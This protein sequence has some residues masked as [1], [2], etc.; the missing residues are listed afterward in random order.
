[1]RT[2]VIAKRKLLKQ[3]AT[4][5]EHCWRWGGVFDSCSPSGSHSVRS[6]DGFICKHFQCVFIA[7]KQMFAFWP[8]GTNQQMLLL[9]FPQA[10]WHGA[11]PSV[12]FPFSQELSCNSTGCLWKHFVE[13]SSGSE[14]KHLLT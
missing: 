14:S 6:C 7:A 3:P 12:S 1:M 5:R 8:V 11:L 10:D 13:L 9:T 4:K 2:P